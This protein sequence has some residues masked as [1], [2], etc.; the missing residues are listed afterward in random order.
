[1]DKLLNI[2]EE[3]LEIYTSTKKRETVKYVSTL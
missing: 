2:Y 1:M 3:L